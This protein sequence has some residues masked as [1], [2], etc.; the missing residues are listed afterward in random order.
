MKNTNVEPLTDEHY[1]WADIV[2]TGGM[3]P[4]QRGILSVIEKAHQ[5]GCPVVVGGPDPS[6]QPFLYQSADYLVHGEGEA[7]IP[8]LIDDLG[9]GCRSGEYK[10]EEKPDMAYSMKQLV[11]GKAKTIEKEKRDA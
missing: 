3:L 6:S 4:Q 1:A 10:S 8:L 11:I 7:T 9:R 5:N 2:C